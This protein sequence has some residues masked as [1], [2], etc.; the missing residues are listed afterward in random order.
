MFVQVIIGVFCDFVA[1]NQEGFNVNFG[2]T[3]H[4]CNLV[5]LVNLQVTSMYCTVSERR[6]SFADKNYAYRHVCRANHT[7]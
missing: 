2:G 5:D 6:Y 4:S 3:L 7:N 1:S